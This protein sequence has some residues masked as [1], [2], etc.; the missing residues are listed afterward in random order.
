MPYQKLQFK[1]GFIRDLT[2]YTNKGGW[3][4]GNLVRF[5]L[6]F[7]QSIGG[8]IKY[9]TAQFLGTCRAIFPWNTLSGKFFNAIGTSLKYYVEYGG[10]FYDVTPL[11]DT[12]VLNNPFTA[13]NGS[14]IINVYDVAHGAL[15]N[16]FVTFSGAASLGGN[17]TAAVLNKQ[18]Q[19]TYVD[20]D[21]YKITVSATANSSD[22]GH[23]GATVTTA[24]QINTG[25]NSALVGGG[26]GAGTW[27]RLT[28]GSAIPVTANLSLRL[29]FQDNFG[30]ILL[31]NVYNGGIYLWN[32]ASSSLTTP[33]YT[34]NRAV[35]L[36]SLSTDATT[37]TLATQVMVSD[38]DR[39]VIAFGANMGGSTS[40]DALL[41]RFSNQEDYTTWTS[42]A[43]NTAGDL[44]LGTGSRII[45]ALET[46]REILVWTDSALYSM[47]FVGPPY[48]FGI[49]QI[50]SATTVIS[51]NAFAAIDDTV[52]WMGNQKFYVYDGAAKELVCPIKNYVFNG[53]NGAQVEK[54]TV[55]V[56]SEFNEVTWF[57]PSTNSSDCD[58]YVTYNYAD[59]AWTYG[60][61][62]RTAWV[63][64]GQEG[65][66]LAA[67]TDG[68]LYYQEYGS[69]D[70]STSPASPLNTYIESAPFDIGEGNQMS[71]VK[72]L[73]PDVS[74]VDSTNSPSLS[75]TVKVQNYPGSNYS[76]AQTTTSAVTQTA[77]VPIEQY[78]NQ[79]SLRLRGR[80]V[81]FRVESNKTDTSWV[82]GSPR[83]DIQ[84]DGRR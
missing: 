45:R 5:R 39:H 58:L 21:N 62:A 38:R 46:K 16:D 83:L 32:P 78:T 2:A 37:P 28:W 1:P 72:Q 61:L 84:P 67:G 49:T 29:W 34:F 55:G 36:A 47:Q 53:M 8:W 81:T 73:I 76:T 48:T 68:Y 4:D 70:G 74:F 33:P 10:A 18:F 23:G 42:T 75:M 12:V 15:D 25:I 79:V 66:P 27:G 80:Q 35:T 51:A 30:E 50:S 82:L 31:F 57:Y 43:T 19:I 77:T 65:Y 41:I 13:T 17:I 11:R 6:G 64:R 24:Y 7:P 60:S 22:T 26:W 59:Q 56:N 44:R 69:N 9:T 54:I 14:S 71:F 63:D 3:Y 40:Q 20:V 52:Y